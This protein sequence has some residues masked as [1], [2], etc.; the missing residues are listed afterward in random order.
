[1]GGVSALRYRADTQV[2]P[3]TNDNNPVY[4]QTWRKKSLRRSNLDVKGSYSFHFPLDF[5]P[6][7]EKQRRNAREADARRRPRAD[8]VAGL[9]GHAGG[10]ALDR[11]RNVEDHV[12]RIAILHTFAVY[13]ADE[14][15][16]VRVG[17]RALMDN[18]RADRAEGIESFAFEPLPVAPLQVA[19]GHIEADGVSEDVVENLVFGYVAPFFTNN[20]RQF[21]F[22]IQAGRRLVM[23][24]FP[25]VANHRRRWLGKKYRCL[26]RVDGYLTRSRPFVDM[27]LVVDSQA[28][29][30]LSRPG[31]RRQEPH[32]SELDRCADA[33]EL[34]QTCRIS[35]GHILRRLLGQIERLSPA[36]DKFLHAVQKRRRS[37]P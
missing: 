13:P 23:D 27:F 32:P 1:M 22:V 17:Q 20:N 33:R 28:D 6:W 5:V 24:H 16:A 21:H 37:A 3:Y 19:R 11:S 8:D 2:G 36:L 9:Q 26:R 18:P 29:H 35:R 34:A 10:E 15:Q 25:L 30:V 7:L 4:R 14:A 12:A 31:Y